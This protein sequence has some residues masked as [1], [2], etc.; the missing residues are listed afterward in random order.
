MFFLT[1]TYLKNHV[2][3][4]LFLMAISFPLIIFLFLTNPGVIIFGYFIEN[5]IYQKFP[6]WAVV[7]FVF[8]I[9]SLASFIMFFVIN[10]FL[11]SLRKRSDRQ[12]KRLQGLFLRLIISYLYPVEQS[13][14][15]EYKTIAR[16]KKFLY[17]GFSKKE[18][19]ISITKVAENINTDF[20]YQFKNL[21]L[22]LKLDG[23]VKSMLYSANLSDKV[24][25]MHIIYYLDLGNVGYLKRIM[26]YSES[27]NFALRTES[28][29]T[30][31]RLMKD[32]SQL[33]EFIGKKYNLSMLDINVIVN[34]IL[35]NPMLKIDFIKLLSSDKTRK[36]LIGLLMAQYKYRDN[37][38]SIILI[39]N[40][41]D[42]ENLMVKRLAWDAYLSLVPEKEGFDLI[43]EH[44]HELDHN[45]KLMIIKHFDF[46]NNKPEIDFLDEIILSEPAS[47]KIEAMKKMF[48]LNMKTFIKYVEIED[49][50]MVSVCSEVI[51]IN[52]N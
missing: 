4:L 21:V 28:Y 32:E 42:N 15:E 7:I 49:P 46:Y 20:S 1:K 40:Q 25:A 6:V 41:L 19:L 43:R 47:I 2:K 11:T 33:V 8:I 14:D 22:K 30:L 26:K 35:N 29:I 3:Y 45:V 17:N 10:L 48:K 23:I 37:S 18:L 13:I 16:I 12:S 34:A 51:D 5:P 9:F 24:L 27:N 52:I 38:R 36:I 39:L 44:Y 50:V 31:I